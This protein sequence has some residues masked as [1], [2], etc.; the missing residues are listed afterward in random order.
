MARQKGIIKL[1]GTIGDI[2]FYKSQDGDLA[3]G[4]GGVDGDR[5][6]ND[7]A[8][9]R[10]RENGAEFG[11]AAAGGK[12]LRDT[13]RPMMMNAADNRV[14]SRIT[15][16]MTQIKT[17]DTASNRGDRSVGIGISQAA[18]MDLLRGFNFNL[19]AVLGSVLRKPFSVQPA[20]GQISINNLVPI[21]DVSYPSG[22]THVTFKS[23]WASVDFANGLASVEYSPPFNL[24]VDAATVNVNCLPPVP[25]QPYSTNIYFL[26]V[27]FFQEVN[28]VQ[29]TLKNGAYNAL[30]IVEIQ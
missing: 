8:F 29:Y 3:R 30:A 19:R 16:I 10:T 21:N 24:P 2:T 12:L 7:A 20:T 14:V 11:N 13:I 17:Y 5:I 6:K 18:A 25:P 22:A 9:A 27:E 4:K 23:A 15:K 28:G 1:K 26:S